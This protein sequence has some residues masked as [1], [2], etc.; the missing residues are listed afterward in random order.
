MNSKQSLVEEKVLDKLET[1]TAQAGSEKERRELVNLKQSLVEEEE[2]CVEE[3]D[4]ERMYEALDKFHH[5]ATREE[6][7]EKEREA[8]AEREEGGTPSLAEGGR[9]EGGEKEGGGKKDKPESPPRPPPP[10]PPPGG[11]PVGA[12]EEKVRKEEGGEP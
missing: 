5:N 11:G 4:I 7:R 3:C 2:V 6:E 12:G 1:T 9:H 8:D 10:P